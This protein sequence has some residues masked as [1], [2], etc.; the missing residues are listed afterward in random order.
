MARHLAQGALQLLVVSFGVTLI[1][2]GLIRLSGNPAA[3]LLPPDASADAI[4]N[5]EVALGLTK[6]WYVQYARF[7]SGLLNSHLGQS[8]VYH[9]SAISVVMQ[10]LPAT[11]ELAAASLCF[12]VPVG[13]GLGVAAASW[14]GSATDSLSTFAA[15]FGQ[16]MPT[17]W[18]GI[19]LIMLF[20]VHLGWFPVF[21]KQSWKSFILPTMTLG[22]FLMPTIFRLT[23]SAVLDIYAENYIRTARAKGVSELWVVVKHALRNAAIP[24]VTVIGLQF[25]N[26]MGG[27]V[28]TEAVFSWPGVGF[29]TLQAVYN[30]DYPLVQASLLVLALAVSLF[31]I[32]IDVA[33]ALLDPRLQY[34]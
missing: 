22:S 16:S 4:K 29:L 5:Y 3:M 11:A 30:F 2:F 19:M 25:A 12:V 28:V 18:I 27:A 32:L 24:I 17:F 15:L 13:V 26:L 21:G 10:H 20:G 23:R 9:R 8:F 33:Y 6:P 7:L 14:R 34:A 31:S 1:A